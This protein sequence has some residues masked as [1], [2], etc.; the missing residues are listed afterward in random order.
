M[1][2][3]AITIL[4]IYPI[5]SFAGFET[6]S[7]S[8]GKRGLSHDRRWMLVDREGVFMTQRSDTRLALF[9]TEMAEFGLRI[10]SP[11]GDRCVAPFIPEGEACK[12][13]VW[14]SG[15]DAVRVS[16]E[17]DRWL[18][19]KLEKECSLVYM[20]ETSIRETHRD[21]TLAGDI[22]GFADA[23][24]VLVISEESLND[25]NARLD[26]ALPMNRFRPNIVLSGTSPFGEDGWT[27][28]QIGSLKFRFAKTCGRCSVTA[29]NQETGEV[30]VEP[31]KTL[32]KYR[33]VG[34]SV[35]FGAYF[36]PEGD[37]V[38]RVGDTVETH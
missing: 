32:A 15:C 2:K 27:R 11:D 38:I 36:V 19:V 17:I 13:Q 9:R 3:V 30:G 18:S 29:T 31:L 26:E 23:F 14:K 8:V 16:S 7:S 4:K 25:L 6:D 24:P 34:K 1:Q 5:K 35:Q 10:V 28:M 20:P 12:V 21:Y 37:G 22:V 33:L